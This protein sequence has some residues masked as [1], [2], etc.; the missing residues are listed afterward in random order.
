MNRF[1]YNIIKKIKEKEYIKY[2]EN[3][4]FLIEQAFDEMVMCP[5]MHW[6]RLGILSCGFIWTNSKTW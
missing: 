3:H 1:I 4:K 5:D 6:I 2:I